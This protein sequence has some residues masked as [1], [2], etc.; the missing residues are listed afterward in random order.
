MSVEDA[1]ALVG[2]LECHSFAVDAIE[3]ENK[4]QG[5]SEE[6]QLKSSISKVV[7]S[8]KSG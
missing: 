7:S 4:I 3:T 2:E 6:S 8:H 5:V 1:M